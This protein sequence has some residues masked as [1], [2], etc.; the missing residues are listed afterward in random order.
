[1]RRPMIRRVALPA[2]AFVAASIALG[3]VA[4]GKGATEPTGWPDVR[5]ADFPPSLRGQIDSLTQSHD[6]ADL[7]DVFDV[8]SEDNQAMLTR[9]GNGTA[10]LMGY[11][12]RS[13][14]DAGCYRAPTVTRWPG[15]GAPPVR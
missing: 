14:D 3:A 8:A 11:L 9:T 10:A 1:M 7:H 15:Y 5:W 4:G 12:Y 6:C 13:M 2:G